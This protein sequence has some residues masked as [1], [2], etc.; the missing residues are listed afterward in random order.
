MDS[1][2]FTQSLHQGRKQMGELIVAVDIGRI[3]LNRISQFQHGRVFTC[4]GIDYTH[5]FIIFHGKVDI[6]KDFLAF[7]T[8]PKG[9]YRN[10]H[11]SEKSE[12]E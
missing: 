12:K 7:A 8:R 11:T 5:T 6:L 9:G 1:V 4:L 10:S 2:A 3:F